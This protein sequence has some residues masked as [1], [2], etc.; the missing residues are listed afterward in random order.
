MHDSTA[1]TNIAAQK[2]DL[3]RLEQK[4]MNL[5]DAVESGAA[6]APLVKKLH[7]RQA[8][9]EAL[10]ATIAAAVGADKSRPNRQAIERKVQATVKVWREKLTTNGRQTL[11]E[12]LD[13]PIR[14]TPTGK[15]YKFEAGLTTGDWIA[16][17]VG[18]PP[19]VASLTNASCNHLNRW[20]TAS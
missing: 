12:L 10:L 11:R 8:E 6:L 20:L 9:R 13:G 5:T 15:R 18:I 17:L 19:Y 3:A 4:I 14:F 7:E 1:P 2:H 16:S